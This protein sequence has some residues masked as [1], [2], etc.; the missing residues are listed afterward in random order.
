MRAG[1]RESPTTLVLLVATST[2]T[3]TESMD[4]IFTNIII[5]LQGWSPTKLYQN[6]Y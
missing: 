5:S 4:T 6:F 1:F 2:I 3:T